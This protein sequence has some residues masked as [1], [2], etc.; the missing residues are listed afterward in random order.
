MVLMNI[1]VL[2]WGFFMGVVVGFLFRVVLFFSFGVS[3]GIV[4][5]RFRRVFG[6][7]ERKRRVFLG[8]VI[9]I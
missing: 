7:G 2:R 9:L 1:S 8:F 5:F 6:R 3:T 4:L